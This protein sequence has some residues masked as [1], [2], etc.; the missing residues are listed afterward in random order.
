MKRIS[1]WASCHIIPA[2]L[3][4]TSI[5]LFLAALAYYTG[6]T[7]YKMQIVLPANVI[8]ACSFLALF[9]AIAIYPKKRNR[10]LKKWGYVQQKSC[11]FIVAGCSF[12][13]ICAG[14]NNG[15]TMK[16][17]PGA[18]GTTTVRHP[19][20]AEDI[21]RSLNSGNKP[22]LSHREKR[23]LKKEFFHQLKI[24]TV[25]KAIDDKQKA[26][27]AWKIILVIIAALGLL[28]V[29]SLLVC[30]LSCNGSGFAATA[31]LVLG[32]AAVIWGSILLIKR[33]QRGP[34]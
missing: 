2:R 27:D 3:L 4:I 12:M 5:T 17:L 19:R 30:T 32:L 24:F 14:V 8:Y 25:A 26:D 28:Y 31:V 13:I 20:A 9:I 21:L 29:L 16:A 23:V 18:Y 34:K 11:D 10:L 15:D 6:I 33:I 7:L 22:S 1:S